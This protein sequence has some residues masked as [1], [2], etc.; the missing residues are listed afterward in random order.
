MSVGAVLCEIYVK[1][2]DDLFIFFL[3]PVLWAVVLPCSSVFPNYLIVGNL[4][5]QCRIYTHKDIL[6]LSEACP[7]QRPLT[8]LAFH[9]FP[10]SLMFFFLPS[11]Q[12]DCCCVHIDCFLV[13]LLCDAVNVILCHYT[14]IG[15]K[16]KDILH[17]IFFPS[18]F[19]YVS[20]QFIHSREW[21]QEWG[22]HQC[23]F[24]KWV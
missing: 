6:A 5:E 12:I 17:Y 22:D 4:P 19:G 21:L 16:R 13:W 11:L 20:H 14:R 15:A 3:F 1:G 18:W 10:V 8:Q 2:V 9:H 24:V 7:E 23:S